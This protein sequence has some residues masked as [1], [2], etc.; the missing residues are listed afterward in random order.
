[1]FELLNMGN[2]SLTDNSNPAQ[3]QLTQVAQYARA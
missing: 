2:L 1:M 3:E